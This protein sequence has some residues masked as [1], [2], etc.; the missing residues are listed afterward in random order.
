VTIK[1]KEEQMPRK[2]QTEEVKVKVESGDDGKS[3]ENNTG[4]TVAIPVTEEIS[5]VDK[6]SSPKV[7]PDDVAKEDSGIIELATEATVTSPPIFETPQATNLAPI[8]T[9]P[10]ETVVVD[11][12][13][14]YRLVQALNR[15]QIHMYIGTAATRFLG[16]LFY[17]ETL[18]EREA[19]WNEV[20]KWN[21]ENR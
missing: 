13:A 16:D 4:A 7:I 12:K 2:K 9:V 19:K 10:R 15:N 17:L 20:K 14:L 18:A 21:E 5:T 11:K 3:A 1:F 8:E 6:L